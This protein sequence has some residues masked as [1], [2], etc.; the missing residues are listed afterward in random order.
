MWLESCASQLTA[1][2]SL[3]N[4]LVSFSYEPTLTEAPFDFY[5]FSVSNNLLSVSRGEFTETA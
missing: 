2:V 5:Q 1:S 4:A 3:F